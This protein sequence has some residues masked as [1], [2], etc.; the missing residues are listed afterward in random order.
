M[1]FNIKKLQDFYVQKI[2]DLHCAE[3]RMLDLLPKMAS[4]VDHAELASVLLEC[5]QCAA[6]KKNRLR[7]LLLEAGFEPREEKDPAFEG[8]AMEAQDV[9]YAEA[10]P[11]VKD[12]AV[13]YTAR[14]L[15]ADQSLC[16]ETL[17]SFA[18]HLG[19]SKS[20]IVLAKSLAEESDCESRLAKLAEGGLLFSGV[21]RRAAVS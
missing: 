11:T 3:K 14:R 2:Q 10:P 8:L 9:L 1:P 15:L 21:H 5:H 17:V 6:E 18:Y 20:K 19:L 4:A 7:R 12:T 13:L 16:Y